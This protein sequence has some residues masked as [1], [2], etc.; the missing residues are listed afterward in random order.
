MRRRLFAFGLVVPLLFAGSSM[1]LA[2]PPVLP[3]SF[4]GT[5]KVDGENAPDGAVVR[6]LIDGQVYAEEYTQTYEGESFY[7]LNVR[8][9]DPG[10]QK[11]DGGCEGD[12]VQFEVGGVLTEQTGIW[13]SGTNVRVDLTVSAADPPPAP[14]VTPSEVPTQTPTTPGQPSPTPTTLGQP[15]PTSTTLGQPAPTPTTL[16]QPAPTS[17]APGQPVPTLTAPRQP[18]PTLTASGQSAPTPTTSGQ[19]A[20][21]P[22]LLTNPGED[23]PS[24]AGL[25]V[26]VVV[27]AVA[28]GGVAWAVRRSI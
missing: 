28:V 15:A 27:A 10:T 8:A 25:I 9:D 3:S 20:P 24:N 17:T 23:G 1:V 4:W 22:V 11:R 16:G 2:G 18:A 14:P 13:H 21:T 26:V 12:V 19:P 7:A 5:V 6:A